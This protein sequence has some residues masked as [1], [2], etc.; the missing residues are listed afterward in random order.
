MKIGLIVNYKNQISIY[1]DRIISSKALCVFRIVIEVDDKS[2]YKK[3]STV[4][5]F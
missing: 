1:N 3:K 2:K 4:Y 5:K